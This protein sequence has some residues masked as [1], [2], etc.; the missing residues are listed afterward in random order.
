MFQNNN[1]NI[2]TNNYY[3]FFL[4]SIILSSK[5]IPLMIN[6]PITMF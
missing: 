2:L 4:F 5:Y 1:A 6:S 3:K